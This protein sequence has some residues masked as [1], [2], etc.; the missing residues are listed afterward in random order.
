MG[1]KVPLKNHKPT[2]SDVARQAGV[3]RVTASVA[4]NG[5]T[6]SGTRVS[7]ATRERVAQAARDLGYTPSA[8]ALAL[9]GNRTN[10]IGY[11]TGYESLDAL[12]P[13]TATIIN[14]IRRVCHFKKQ[15]LLMFGSYERDSADEIYASLSNG[16]ID[17]LVLLPSPLSPVMDHLSELRLP[18]VAIANV[19]PG[20]PSVGV[21]DVGGARMQAE[22]LAQ[23]G[24]QRI[25]YR[26]D[27]AE[28]RS[29]VRR[30]E[31]FIET[32]HALG[33]EV[34]V[35]RGNQIGNLMPAELEMLARP[36]SLRPTAAVCW[37]D[38]N[39]YALLENLRHHGIHV[40]ADLAVMGFDGLA[41]KVRSAWQLTSI[42]APWYDV[43]STAVMHLLA[44]IEGDEVKGEH[45]FPVELLEGDTA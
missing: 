19:M 8:I 44:L 23:K 30:R 11:Y 29:T 13:F 4:L 7:Q 28:H 45:I 17:G 16:K 6:H 9:R 22:Y 33:M 31:A 5:S 43:A 21:D 39:A 10:I 12:D 37:A 25:L 24:H 15:D 40:P 1:V 3:N 36:P 34:E 2:L 26:A 32:A 18:V 14:G 27:F 41:P 35:V 20:V 38:S 42:R